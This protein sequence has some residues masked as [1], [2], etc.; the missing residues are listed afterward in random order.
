[1]LPYHRVQSL[2]CKINVAIEAKTD[3]RP[4]ARCTLHDLGLLQMKDDCAAGIG[5]LTS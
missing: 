4:Y 2:T 5:G 1:M 3:L